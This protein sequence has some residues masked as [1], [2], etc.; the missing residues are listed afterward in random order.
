MDLE[1]QSAAKYA[2]KSLLIVRPVEAP[3]LQRESLAGLS[4]RPRAPRGGLRDFLNTP[5]S[6]TGR[7][8]PVTPP[9]DRMC[10]AN[11]CRLDGECA[12]SS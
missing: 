5:V 7:F 11:G 2:G 10:R 3:G 6:A 12:R 8:L 4:C 1:K 9:A